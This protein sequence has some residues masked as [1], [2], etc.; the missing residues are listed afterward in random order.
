M[1]M[2]QNSNSRVSGMRP[3]EGGCLE[4]SF[5]SRECFPLCLGVSPLRS[6]SLIGTV[7]GRSLF[8]TMCVKDPCVHLNTNGD[9]ADGVRSMVPLSR[10]SQNHSREADLRDGHGESEQC[11][12]T[13]IDVP[14]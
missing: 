3:T 9:E 2:W 12:T 1:A 4:Q 13:G 8:S 14:P 5:P 11:G 7:A 6:P 10:D